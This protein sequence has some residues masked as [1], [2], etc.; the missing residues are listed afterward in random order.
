MLLHFS[1]LV[2][3]EENVMMGLRNLHNYLLI[4]L[5]Q[6]HKDKLTMVAIIKKD[7]RQSQL[8]NTRQHDEIQTLH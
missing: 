2:E 7:K 3:M 5:F 6:Q 1:V 8:H 4:L